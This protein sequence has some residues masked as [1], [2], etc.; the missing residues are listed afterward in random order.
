MKNLMTLIMNMVRM[1]TGSKEKLSIADA[2]QL[3]TNAAIGSLPQKTIFVDDNSTIDDVTDPGF[4]TLAGK[5]ST[6]AVSMK[7]PIKE[8]NGW[9]FLLVIKSP[10]YV[11]QIIFDVQY[12]IWVPSEPLGVY[13]R[14]KNYKDGSSWTSWNKLGGVVKA[15]LSTLHPV[16]VG[17]LA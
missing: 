15:L 5:T 14:G 11:V 7:L 13:I 17:C 6:T 9:T 10:N 1:L 4:Y 2:N 16:K 12:S 3:L 8:Q